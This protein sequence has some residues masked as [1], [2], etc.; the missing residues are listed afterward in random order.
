MTWEELVELEPKL[1]DLEEKVR[2]GKPNDLIKWSKDYKPVLTK[3]V[4]YFRKEG[5]NALKTTEAY[6][7]AYYYLLDIVAVDIE[8]KE[9]IEKL[10]NDL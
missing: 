4:G 2:K 8:E 3:L 9:E 6:T 7:T 10:K 5:P 1:L